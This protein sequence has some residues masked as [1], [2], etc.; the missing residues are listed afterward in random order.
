MPHLEQV[1]TGGPV[2]ALLLGVAPADGIDIH[3][4]VPLSGLSSASARR[5][6]Q[7]FVA[8]YGLELGIEAW[9]DAVAYAWEHYETLALMANP[10][11]YLYRVGQSS[12]RRQ[13]RW[14]RRVVLPPVPP[15]RLPDVEPALP[16]A[17]ASLSP[18][19][20][21]AVLLVHAHGWTHEEAAT[22]LEIDV[23]TLRNH[24]RRGLLKLRT[25]LGVD[26]A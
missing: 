22:A 23:S 9:H 3:V 7:L 26:D 25:K 12:V 8:R 13:R 16:A 10:D 5:L 21:L 20:R 2:S 24:L 17:L 1:V 6:R 4:D 11:G 15:D 14:R 19:Q 18:Q